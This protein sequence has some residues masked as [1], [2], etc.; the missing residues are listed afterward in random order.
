MREEVDSD[1]YD[2]TPMKVQT[3]KQAIQSLDNVEQ[4]LYSKGHTHEAMQINTCVDA[5]YN[6]YW[7]TPNRQHLLITSLNFNHGIQ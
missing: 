2:D 3:Y 4:F 5:H 6:N 1:D 7:H